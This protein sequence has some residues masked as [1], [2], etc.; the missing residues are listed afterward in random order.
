MNTSIQIVD[1]V[2]W[3]GVRHPDLKV[4]DDLFPTRNGT[5]YN[6]YLIQG[7]EKTALID[8]VKAPFAD[9][10]FAKVGE[11][12]DPAKVDIVV[13]NHT[14]PDH[15]GAVAHILEK[16]P[17]V[18][19]YCSKAAENFLK[20][21][22]NRSFN[23]VIVNDGDEIDLGGKRLRFIIA[24]YLHWP[25]TIFTYLVEEEL[26]F[27]CDAFGAHYCPDMLFD[28][29]INEFYADFHFYF[30][31]IVRPFK[32]KVRDAL[33]K[34]EGLPI[35]MV[36]PSHGPIRRSSGQFAIESYARWCA[37][38]SDTGRPKVL[39]AVLSSHGN[40]RDMAKVIET[41]LFAQGL[42][43]T[44]FALSDMRDDDYRDAL[45]HA[46]V[47]LIG[48]PTIQRDAPP[49]V[50]HALSL[51]SSVT[52]KAKLGAVFGSFGWSGEAVKMVEQRL[53]GLKYKLAADGISFRF[54]PT[55]E[56]MESCRS[57]A[58]KVASTVLCE[59]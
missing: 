55:A 56:N 24:P 18:Q 57:F 21:L 17:D 33:A 12:I 45:E 39:M 1:G 51:I 50:W 44:T 29:E 16:N 15:S 3:V 37:A 32:D 49:H 7:S 38:P 10:F 31:C 54:T 20:Q 41:E 30:D 9:E 8:T 40:T 2:H 6:S 52:P 59:E 19:I 43:V 26:L 53:I 13:V 22:L 36:C 25:D 27:S 35:K 46:D 5:T 11:H 48:T 47:L 28:D 4:F 23:A 14:E 34:C 58:E 42:D